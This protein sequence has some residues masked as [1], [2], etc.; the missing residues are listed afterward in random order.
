VDGPSINGKSGAFLSTQPASPRGPPETATNL[1]RTPTEITLYHWTSAFPDV[2]NDTKLAFSDGPVWTSTYKYWFWPGMQGAA[3]KLLKIIVDADTDV[4][5]DPKGHSRAYKCSTKDGVGGQHN[6]VVIRAAS[7]D[8]V[9]KILFSTTDVMNIINLHLYDR[10]SVFPLTRERQLGYDLKRDLLNSYT[11][12]KWP[13]TIS[14]CIQYD[15][16]SNSTVVSFQALGAHKVALFDY[17]VTMMGF[18]SPITRLFGDEILIWGVVDSQALTL[19]VLHDKL[20]SPGW[21]LRYKS[22]L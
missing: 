4:F 10:M 9:G 3:T 7:F 8:V 12:V 17:F 13:P 2:S 6:D 1:T 11:E 19:K 21:I 16:A 18:S 14:D 20:T 15:Y 5:I 22:A